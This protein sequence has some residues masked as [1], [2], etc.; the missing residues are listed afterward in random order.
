MTIKGFSEPKRIPRIGKIYLG[1]KKSNGNKEYPSAVDYFVVRPD[2]VNTSETAA[3]AFHETYGPEPRELTIAFPSND[4]ED[5]MPQYLASY[6][7]GGGRSE[8]WCKG[9]GET[10]RRM[11]G[12]GGYV[13]I[14]CLYQD[15]PIFQQKKCKPLTRLL[16]LLPDVAGIGIWELD[17]TS[18]Y[19][20]QNLGSSVH[21][22]RQMMG[23]RISMIPMTLRIIPQSVNPEGTIKTVYVLDLQLENVKWRDMINRLPRL[24]L[25]DAAKIVEPSD[26]M[27]DD[28]YVEDS[29]VT[30]QDI[31]RT[32]S[33]T[34]HRPPQ[35]ARSSRPQSST[36]PQPEPSTQTNEDVKDIFGTVAETEVKPNRRGEEVARLKL[37]THDGEMV[38]AMTIDPELVSSIKGIGGGQV[39]CIQTIP[40]QQWSNRLQL[41]KLE[42][43]PAM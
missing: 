43:D 18:Y 2:G 23:G 3:Q 39:V 16:F 13:E 24:E 29:L 14:D 25:T 17:T 32:P 5:F 41:V 33:P 28:L 15:C 12:Q 6:H 34:N 35:A 10:A 22:Y 40:S 7:G 4:P 8:L 42:F 19:S 31:Q 20:A 27:P 1:I 30:E 9:N 36:P 11:D 37:A 21:L 38:E 26:E